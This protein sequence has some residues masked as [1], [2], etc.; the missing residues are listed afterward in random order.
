MD[1]QTYCWI[2]YFFTLIVCLC[3]PTRTSWL[4]NLIGSAVFAVFGFILW[5]IAVVVLLRLA[6][7]I[8]S[9]NFRAN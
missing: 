9:K 6:G 5:P 3:I 7:V 8:P 1:I 2:T 4:G